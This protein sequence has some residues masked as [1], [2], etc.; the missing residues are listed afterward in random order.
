[1]DSRDVNWGIKNQFGG[2]FLKNWGQVSDI[3]NNFFRLFF[4]ML[5]PLTI[6]KQH[7]FVIFFI[8]EIQ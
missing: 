3:T 8:F 5:S 4:G 1:M 7:F 6:K 2:H